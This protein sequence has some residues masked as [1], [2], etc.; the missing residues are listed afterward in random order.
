MSNCKDC[1][2]PNS[3]NCKDKKVNGF[4]AKGVVKSFI[5]GARKNFELVSNNLKKAGKAVIKYFDLNIRREIALKK[6]L[7]EKARK[8]R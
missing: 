4:N 8:S 7:E 1:K 6:Y 3:C 5:S 2:N